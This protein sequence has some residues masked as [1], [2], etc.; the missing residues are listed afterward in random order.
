MLKTKLGHGKKSLKTTA[1]G[2][3]TMCH[4]AGSVLSCRHLCSPPLLCRPSVLVLLGR[5]WEGGCQGML[6]CVTVLGPSY[7]G[8]SSV[9]L[10]C[11]LVVWCYFFGEEVREGIKINQ[12]AR[13]CLRM[14]VGQG[15]QTSVWGRGVRVPST[16]SSCEATSRLS[17]ICPPFEGLTKKS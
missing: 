3:V 7:P 16:L 13:S 6:R 2:C 17:L 11:R 8:V 15:D 5:R 10:A 9:H 14:H 1:L 12:S 4:W